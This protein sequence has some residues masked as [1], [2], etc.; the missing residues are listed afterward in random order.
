MRTLTAAHVDPAKVVQQAMLV[1][2]AIAC[3]GLCAMVIRIVAVGYG[4]PATWLATGNAWVALLTLPSLIAIGMRG[5]YRERA[6]WFFWL[7][8][9][10]A[11]SQATA[12][13]FAIAWT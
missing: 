10:L 1:G 6:K 11:P 2:T 5:S 12:L 9:A 13:I 3:A 8:L 7:G 4:Y